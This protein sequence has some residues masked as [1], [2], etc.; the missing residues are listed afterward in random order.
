M[1]Q[2]ETKVTQQIIHPSAGSILQP[3]VKH[4]C[5]LSG[6]TESSSIH[7]NNSKTAT[8]YTVQE[9]TQI[10]SLRLTQTHA[11]VNES[12]LL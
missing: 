5:S 7:S 12:E 4:K 8:H 3:F 6:S 2:R 1:G 11:D 9:S 10:I